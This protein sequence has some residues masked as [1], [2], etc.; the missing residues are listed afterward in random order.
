MVRFCLY[1]VSLIAC[2]VCRYDSAH[3]TI[4]HFGPL[5]NSSLILKHL[6]P[7]KRILAL[8][9]RGYAFFSWYFPAWCML[10]LVCLCSDCDRVLVCAVGPFRRSVLVAARRSMTA[11]TA[12]R[13]TTSTWTRSHAQCHV[14]SCCCST[15]KM[16]GRRCASFWR[17]LCLHQRF[18]E[19]TKQPCFS[20]ASA[21]SKSLTLS[22]LPV[23]ALLWLV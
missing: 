6:P 17:N 7:I 10:V 19:A 3:N 14:T 16:A 12:W 4:M 2:R 11:N 5:I 22:L 9:E 20:V 15:S 21:C 18:R 13:S 23:L 8:H 1:S